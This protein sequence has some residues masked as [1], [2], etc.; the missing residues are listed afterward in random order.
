LFVQF[1]PRAGWELADTV[2]FDIRKTVESMWDPGTLHMDMKFRLANVDN[3]AID[4]TKQ[5]YAPIAC[6]PIMCFDYRT[7]KVGTNIISGDQQFDSYKYLIDKMFCGL[8]EEVL[9]QVME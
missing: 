5:T 2:D 4:D 7:V 8:S 9:E 6:F 1:Y 3:S